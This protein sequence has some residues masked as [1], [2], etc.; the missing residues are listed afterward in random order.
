[1][2]VNACPGPDLK[3]ILE[4]MR[5]KYESMIEGNRKEVEAW[6]ESK[7]SEISVFLTWNILGVLEKLS[8]PPNSMG[9][10]SQ[11]L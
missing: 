5:C 2:E 11:Y 3:K 7:V 8:Y 9:I 4:E 10:E 6:Y 1:M